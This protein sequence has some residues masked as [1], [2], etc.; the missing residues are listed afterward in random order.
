MAIIIM[1]KDEAE[2]R[3]A[4]NRPRDPAIPFLSVHLKKMK[5]LI[6]KDTCTPILIA[7][8]SKKPRYESNVSIHHIHQQMNA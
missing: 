7:E 6:W 4:S 5:A 3:G 8:F 2:D 1:E